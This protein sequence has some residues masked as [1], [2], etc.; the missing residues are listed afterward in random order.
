MSNAARAGAV[1]FAKNLQRVAMF[2]EELLGLPAVRA[3]SDHVVL[4]SACCELL[5]HA[6]PKRIADTIEISV[7]HERRSETPIKLHFSA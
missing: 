3:E 6:I 5:I 7:P 1:A 4:A 2:C